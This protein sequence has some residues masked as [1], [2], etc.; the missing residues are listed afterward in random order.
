MI[1]KMF[2][3]SLMLFS[4]DIKS[5]GNIINGFIKYGCLAN[6]NRENA[7]NVYV[8]EPIKLFVLD[9]F[10]YFPKIMNDIPVRYN[11]IRMIIAYKVSKLFDLVNRA[12]YDKKSPKI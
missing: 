5:S 6:A 8:I 4:I 7:L 11:L 12:V 1:K 2:L 10:L 3:F 9:S